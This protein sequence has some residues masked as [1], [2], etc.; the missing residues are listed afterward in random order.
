MIK[1][2]LKAA[3]IHL[4]ISALIVGSF[5]AFALTVW[6]PTPFFEISGLLRIILILVT[7][8]VI[9]GP[10]LTL[11]VY[12]PL[13]ATLKMDLTVIAAV[14]IVALAYG[15]HIIHQAHP[16]YIAYAGDRF[17]PIN[18]NEVSPDV[19]KHAELQKSKLSG[20]TVVYVKK[21]SDPAEMSRVT[22]EVLSGKPDIDARPE[23]YELFDQFADEVLQ[24][25]L[26]LRQVTSIPEN[27]QKLT[28]FLEKYGKSAADYAYLP[29]IGKEKDVLWVWDRINAKPVGTLDINPWQ[30]P[31]VAANS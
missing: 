4:V 21:P 3:L 13:K 23:Y 9:L 26:T 12:K 29:L 14:Q 18:A 17:T 11:V 15:I 31:K 30:L 2:K 20:P 28:V 1:H 5:L 25:G 10:L 7:V 24:K 6:Y 19:A 22:M 27:Q 16:L 8:D